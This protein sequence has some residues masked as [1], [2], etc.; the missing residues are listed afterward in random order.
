MRKCLSEIIKVDISGP[1]W[2]P[3]ALPFA[4]GGLGTRRTGKRAL[5][6]FPASAHSVCA[7]SQRITDFDLQVYLDNSLKLWKAAS[8]SLALVSDHFN[9]QKCWDFCVTKV[10]FSRINTLLTDDP[11]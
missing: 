3:A 9:F 11:H 4:M 7:L 10:T 1:H 2:I 5:P 8:T 6:A